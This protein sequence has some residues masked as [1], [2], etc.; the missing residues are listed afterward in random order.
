M[1]N[2]FEN[3]INAFVRC[4]QTEER[5]PSHI[6]SVIITQRILQAVYDSAATHREIVF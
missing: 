1:T 4:I 3:E 2:H 5:L 6:D